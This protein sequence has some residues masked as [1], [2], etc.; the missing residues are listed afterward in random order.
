MGLTNKEKGQLTYEALQKRKEQR[1]LQEKKKKEREAMGYV[2]ETVA[3]LNKKS[4][5]QYYSFRQHMR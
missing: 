5:Q 3:R 1:E 4:Y 2:C